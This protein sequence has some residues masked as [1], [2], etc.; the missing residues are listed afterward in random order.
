MKVVRVISGVGPTW[1]MPTATDRSLG[2]GKWSLGPTAVALTMHGPWVFGGLMSNQWSIAGWGDENVIS[3][4]LQPFLNYNLPDGWYLTSSPVM[5]AN[6]KADSGERWTVPL[7]GG[8][9]KVFKIGRQPINAQL[10]AYGNV[11]KPKFGPDWQL[12]FQIQF[13]FPKN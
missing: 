5:T 8:F 11:E 12:R 13:L 3:F 7:G 1:T 6:W 9:G 4:L 10:A 2:A